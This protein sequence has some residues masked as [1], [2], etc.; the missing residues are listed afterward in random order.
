MT[1]NIP[2]FVIAAPSSGS[3]KSTIA[4]GLMAALSRDHIVQGFK[5]GPD[6]I[7]PGYHTAAAGRVSRNLDTW[8]VPI[9]EVKATFARAVTADPPA[10]I[11]IVEGVMGLFDG[12]EAKTESGS[13]AQVAKLIDAP[14]ILVINVGKMA[15]SAGAIALGYRD[16]DPDLKVAGVICNNVGSEKHAMWVTEAI[17]SIGLPVLGCIPRS[18]ALRIPERHLGLQTAIERTAELQAFMDHAA[19]LVVEHIDL[20][21][22]WELAA[23]TP[24]YPDLTPALTRSSAFDLSPLQNGEGEGELPSGSSEGGEVEFNSPRIAIAHDEAFCFYYEDNFDWL[25]AAGAEVI[26][27]SPLHDSTLPEGINGLYLG[28]GYPELYAAQLAENAAMQ[29]SIRAAVES[30]MP[31]FAE[32]GGLMFLTDS[33]TDLDGQIHPMIGVVP[34]RA[35]MHGRLTMGYRQVTTARDTILLPEG[36]QT[37]GH[38]F[39]YSD[40]VDRPDDLPSAYAISPRAAEAIQMEG[41]AKNNVLASYVHLHFGAN[42][43]LA[44]NFVRACQEWVK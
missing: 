38:E 36:E 23:N 33:I 15:R 44:T 11:A 18:E 13:T 30:G 43:D 29:N 41:Y 9:D 34:G 42:P 6:Y 27:F 12:Y 16:F 2:R 40:W 14:V 35:Q 37:R 7:D 17:E 21:R 3:G 31:T 8:M 22:V 20:V 1:I 10:E 39:H 26:F 4:T 24:P 32:C 25:R 19:S 5:V 28:G